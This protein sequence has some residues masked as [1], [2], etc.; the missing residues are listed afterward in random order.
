MYNDTTIFIG[1][2]VHK[3]SI[4]AAC[5]GSEPDASV[6][7]L[8]TLGTPQYAIDRL[9][10]KLPSR[11]QVRLAYEAGPCGF[12]LQ[13]YLASRG[14]DCQVIAPS[15]IPKKPGERIKTDRRDA[16]KLALAFRAGLLTAVPIPTPEQ[17][18]FRDMV[19]AWQQAKK[20]PGPTG[21]RPRSR[22][23]SKRVPA[24]SIPPSA[25]SP[26]VPRSDCTMYS[27][28]SSDA[29]NT[30]MSRLRL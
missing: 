19:R 20:Q 10:K 4:M 2:D 7:D 14:Y 27:S 24:T 12:W 3:D 18:Q 25:P 22:A 23:S 9:L 1:L 30:A 11:D 5:V 13:R 16:P 26:G 29:A 6:V 28:S 8:G 17:E 21:I 15:L